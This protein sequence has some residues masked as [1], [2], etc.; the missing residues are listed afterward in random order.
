MIESLETINKR[1]KDIH[2][3]D[4]YGKQKYRLVFA[5][6]EL[7]KRKSRFSDYYAKVILVR[8]VEEV[9]E[10][11]KYPD[12]LGRYILETLSPCMSKDVYNHNGYEP[13][14]VFQ[15]NDGTPIDPAWFAIE[16]LI[17]QA[18]TPVEKLTQKQL[19]AIEA[20]DELKE[21]EKF[22]E[23]LNTPSQELIV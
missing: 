23:Y 18:T 6:T 21:A 4:I 1:L 3:T 19:D 12:F 5:D 7:E 8:S 16:Y 17:K 20:E 13:L 15:R 10:V 14:W 22:L 11:H 9:R 2:G